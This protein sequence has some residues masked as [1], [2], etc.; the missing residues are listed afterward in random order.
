VKGGAQLQE[1]KKNEK[2]KDKRKAEK[3]NRSEEKKKEK[4]GLIEGNSSLF[5]NSIIRGLLFSVSPLEFKGF[6]FS[7]VSLV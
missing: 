6:P 3:K 7:V 1:K 2:K 5:L 4:Q